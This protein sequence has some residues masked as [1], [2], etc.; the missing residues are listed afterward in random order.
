MCMAEGG[1]H[2][3]PS[4]S[5]F[6]LENPHVLARSSADLSGCTPTA[7]WAFFLSALVLSPVAQPS[8]SA[9]YNPAQEAE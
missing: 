8:S 6:R 5:L 4:N 7:P 2:V 1:H 9:F 3:Q